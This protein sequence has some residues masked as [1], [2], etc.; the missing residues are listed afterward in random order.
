MPRKGQNGIEVTW[1][2]LTEMIADGRAYISAFIPDGQKL[3]DFGPEQV[4][5]TMIDQEEKGHE[6]RD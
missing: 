4:Q 1:D 3:V 2:E 5:I 6:R